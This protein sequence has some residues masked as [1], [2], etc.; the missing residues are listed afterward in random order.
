VSDTEPL[1]TFTKPQVHQTFGI[2]VVPEDIGKDGKLTEA[3]QES[4]D[5][6]LMAT[7]H[8]FLPQVPAGTAFRIKI[9]MET[10]A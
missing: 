2:L 10:V 6:L 4:V 5:R 1:F 7:V 9:E 3:S 8:R